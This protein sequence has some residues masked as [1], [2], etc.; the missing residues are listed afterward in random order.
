MQR[1]HEN[2]LLIIQSFHLHLEAPMC[3]MSSRPNI[4]MITEFSF[5]FFF[6]FFWSEYFDVL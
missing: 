3:F 5:S 1:K 4:W 2:G 6:L